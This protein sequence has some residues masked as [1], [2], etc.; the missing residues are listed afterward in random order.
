MHSR[1]ILI[2]ILT[3]SIILLQALFCLKIS[4]QLLQT[5][6]RLLLFILLIG[7][8]RMTLYII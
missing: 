5:S 8:R 4:L 3:L 1:S 7:G 2:H 6:F